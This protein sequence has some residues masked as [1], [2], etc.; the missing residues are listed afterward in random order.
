MIFIKVDSN[1][2]IQM[3]HYM[4]FHGKYGLHKTEAQ[5]LKEGYLV[6]SVPEFEAKEGYSAVTKFNTETK[7][8][9]C[10]YVEIPQPE[11]T[12]NEQ[13]RADID[14]LAVMMGVEL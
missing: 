7:E 10:E 14:F 1:H 5:L 3:T 8:F 4:P 2:E 6:E 13:L 11:P 12:E 9:Y